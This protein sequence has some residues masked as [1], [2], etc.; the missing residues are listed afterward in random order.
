MRGRV[1][2]QAM[3]PNNG[4]AETS[5]AFLERQLRDLQEIAKN[6]PGDAEVQLSLQRIGVIVQ[7]VREGR[8]FN[9]MYKHLLESFERNGG[10]SDVFAR[11]VL[12]F[13]RHYYDVDLGT[14]VPDDM[15]KLPPC[16]PKH[17][18]A[19]LR[20][21][22]PGDEWIQFKDLVFMAGEQ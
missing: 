17:T 22:V 3:A 7:R 12:D 1:V 2:P 13:Y 11:D 6:L 18:L 20:G 19:W 4:V 5:L 10:A 9:T 21:E 14:V 8:D 16:D 15:I